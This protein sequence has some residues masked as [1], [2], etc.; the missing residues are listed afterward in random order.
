MAVHKSLIPLLGVAAIIGLGVWFVIEH[1]RRL[2]LAEAH[3]ALEKQADQMAESI[4]GQSNV[5]ASAGA[6]RNLSDDESRELLR[7][8]GQVGILRQQTK[9]LGSAREENRQAHA[10]LETAQKSQVAA[11]PKSA[12][13][14]DY[15]PQDSWTFKGYGSPDATLQ[16]SL[17][18]ANNGDLKA[19]MASV[20]GDLQKAIEEDLKGKSETEAQ[21]KAMDEVM[22]F[23]SVRILNR[24]TR[25]DDVTV[26][27]IEMEGP[28]G[29]RRETMVLKRIENDWKLAGSN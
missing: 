24:E 28:T 18:A 9:E 25:G 15:W 5:V 20:T 2:A 4:A 3:R 14:A 16:S 29:T 10:T 17:W 19:L 23:K 22:G 1:Q 12:A 11:G 26:L 27:S 6:S 7:L 8:R 21:V 13:T